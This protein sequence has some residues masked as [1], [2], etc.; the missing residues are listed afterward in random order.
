MSYKKKV[1]SNIGSVLAARMSNHLWTYRLGQLSTSNIRAMKRSGIAV[2]TSEKGLDSP[3]FSDLQPHAMHT[4]RGDTHPSIVVAMPKSSKHATNLIDAQKCSLMVGHTD[5]QIFHWFKQ[6]G[7]VPPRSLVSGAAHILTGDMRDEV[8]EETLCRHPIIHRDA[9][10][11]WN[12]D[13][14]KTQ[15]EKDRVEKLERAEDEA[16]M[17]KLSS[18]DWRGKFQERMKNPSKEQEE[19]KPIFKMKPDSYTVVRL[20]PEVRLWNTHTGDVKK[21]Y[22][23]VFAP[24]GN[25]ARCTPRFLK[26]MNMSREQLIPSLN[27][28]YNLKLSN[29]FVFEIDD[30]GF[31][32]MG[33]QEDFT[34]GDGKESWYEFRCEF[35]TGMVH[36][37]AADMEWWLRGLTRQG[38]AEISSANPDHNDA[39][40]KTDADFRHA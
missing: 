36:K 40:P 7:T 29:G 18:S 28:N 3:V 8:W 2:S 17:K 35:G 21:V 9:E 4:F 31:Y 32:L 11:R 33:T 12:E 19:E 10:D 34:K 14:T 6:L 22:E 37:G 30:T 13:D 38:S 25:L 1:E 15:A 5:P 26:I 27:I 24:I 16:R 23:P 20:V 39:M